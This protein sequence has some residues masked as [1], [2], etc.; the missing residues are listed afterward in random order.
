MFNIKKNLPS[1]EL[2]LAGV[3]PF[4]LISILF[5]ENFCC[6]SLYTSSSGAL[7][8]EKSKPNQILRTGVRKGLDW[9]VCGF[10]YSLNVC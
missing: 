4:G 1:K 10:I 6:R 8:L 5:S 9:F 2:E 3:W 7:F